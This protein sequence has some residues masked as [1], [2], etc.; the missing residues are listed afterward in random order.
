MS[1]RPRTAPPR[2][3]R[4][5]GRRAA[6]LAAALAASLGLAAS[7]SASQPVATARL[8]A[9]EAR[10]GEVSV[11][12]ARHPTGGGD[13]LEITAPP[14]RTIRDLGDASIP[15]DEAARREALRLLAVTPTGDIALADAIADPAA[16]LTLVDAQGNQL[17]VA[18]PGA[19]GAAFGPGGWLVAVDASGRAWR[20]EPGSG[21]VHLLAEGP[22]A[23]TISV[24]RDGALVMVELSSAEAPIASRLVR[25][26]PESGSTTALTGDEI[27]LVFAVRP[28]D[29]GSLAVVSHRT[30]R[31]VEL[32]RL[33]NR[34]LTVE[35][36]LADDAVDPA[37]SADGHAVAYAI[38]GDGSYLAWAGTDGP[39]VRIGDGALPRPGPSGAWFAL[40]D[41]G[42]TVVVDGDGSLRAQVGS[43]LVAWA[44]CA[45]RCGR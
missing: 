20:I 7:T 21:A 13:L 23:G 33:A 19:R 2:A 3:A 39:A 38:A 35:A 11:S 28:L 22:Y 17:R 36:T 6:L 15:A 9:A 43:M 42:R 5:R 24:D 10:S 34:R 14:A 40:L 30:G 12:V 29:D 27:G 31:G 18:L 45:G 25:L 8:S 37:I 41:R 26:D 32:L 1:T 44:P 16:G 4:P